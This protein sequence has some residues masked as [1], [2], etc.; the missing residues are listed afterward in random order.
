M[1]I[2]LIS[3]NAEEQLLSL[4]ELASRGDHRG[5]LHFAGSK[6]VFT[7]T[8]ED[9]LLTVRPVLESMPAAIY[10][11]CNGDIVI[12][13][14]GLQGRVLEPL[15][16]RLYERYAPLASEKLHRYFDLLAQGEELRLLCKSHLDAPPPKTAVQAS[17]PTG[18]APPPTGNVLE[19][20]ENQLRQFR[21]AK[22]ARLSRALPEMLVVE[23]QAFSAKLLLNMLGRTY[24]TYLAGN[25]EQALELYSQH[26]PDIVFLDIELP[27]MNGHALAA[28]LRR[29]DPQAYIVMVTANNYTQ[30][31]LRAKENQVKGFV[32]KPYNK[33][34][35]EGCIEKFR[36]ERS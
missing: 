9:V 20:S 35:I 30:D 23:D 17:G 25:A 10:F 1:V 34:K 27:D 5:V 13:W 11:F 14:K 7:P 6:L 16:A 2:D 36:H 18:P 19:F 8:E 33:Q 22:P 31:V 24:R 15:C 29:M 28:M 4:I 32:A 12:T 26:A 3:Q 21:R